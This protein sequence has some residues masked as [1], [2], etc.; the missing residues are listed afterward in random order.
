MV[1]D[2]QMK[3]KKVLSN[4]RKTDFLIGQSK[5]KPQETSDF[6]LLTQTKYFRFNTLLILFGS[7]SFEGGI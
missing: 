5:D 7:A 6:T 4:A 1:Y 3:E 2:Y